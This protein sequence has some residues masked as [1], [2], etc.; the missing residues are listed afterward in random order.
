[1]STFTSATKKKKIKS[2]FISYSYTK[3]RQYSDNPYLSITFFFICFLEQFELHQFPVGSLFWLS[4]SFWV[5]ALFLGNAILLA[6]PNNCWLSI[7]CKLV[8][9]AHCPLIET[10]SREDQSCSVTFPPLLM[11]FEDLEGILFYIHQHLK[12]FQV[13]LSVVHSGILKYFHMLEDFSILS[14]TQL[15]FFIVIKMEVMEDSLSVDQRFGCD[16]SFWGIL[17][18]KFSR[19]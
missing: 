4:W 9:S 6:L 10:V 16:L 19:M 12:W 17:S 14:I 11:I 3:S 15:Q 7:I 18:E 13:I 5:G 8:K 1:M 2:H